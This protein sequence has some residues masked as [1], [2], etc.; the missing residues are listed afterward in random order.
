MLDAAIPPELI[1]TDYVCI[2]RL[3][4]LHRLQEIG[5]LTYNLASTTRI[6]DGFTVE[7][8]RLR[9]LGSLG[10]RRGLYQHWRIAARRKA[11]A[12]GGK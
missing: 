4:N 5:M 8:G 10:L 11:F 2:K 12:A 6:G 1:P 7:M 3:A 9:P